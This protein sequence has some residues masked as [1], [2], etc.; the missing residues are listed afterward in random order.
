M[1]SSKPW[2]VVALCLSLPLSSITMY[3]GTTSGGA[4]PARYDLPHAARPGGWAQVGALSDSSGKSMRVKEFKDNNG[5]RRALRVDIDAADAAE[6]VEIDGARD[7]M[8]AAGLTFHP[9]RNASGAPV[10]LVLS[11][12]D[13][14]ATFTLSQDSY[15]IPATADDAY[16]FDRLSRRFANANGQGRMQ[17]MRDILLSLSTTSSS[18]TGRIHAELDVFA[19]IMDILAMIVDWIGVVAACGAPILDLFI[20]GL[21][22]AWAVADTI[23]QSMDMAGDCTA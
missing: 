21:A 8:R 10:G 3:G 7:E 23:K 2:I 15:L 14:A 1:K 19:C 13:D 20:C 9:L 22:I 12:D 11:D 17:A 18:S 4:G 6:S 5:Q 16:R